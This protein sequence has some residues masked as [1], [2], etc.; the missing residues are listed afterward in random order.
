VTPISETR[1]AAKVLCR[2]RPRRRR[3][4]AIDLRQLF[5]RANGALTISFTPR[6]MAKAI[7]CAACSRRTSATIA[8]S[9]S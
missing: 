6:W 9:P 5:E 7:P 1:D 3:A 4:R 8:N 2:V